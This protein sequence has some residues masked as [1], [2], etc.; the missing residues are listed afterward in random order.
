MKK[1]GSMINNLVFLFPVM[2][3]FLLEALI[4]GAV[5]TFAWKIFLSNQIGNIGYPQ[6]VVLYWIIK[7]LFFDVFKLIQG[8][9]TPPPPEE[10][11]DEN[12]LTEKDFR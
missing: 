11:V 8:I 9:S 12:Q 2:G 6:V 7:M 5:V 1:N 3:Y 4:V 10:E